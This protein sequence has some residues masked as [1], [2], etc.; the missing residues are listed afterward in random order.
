M[1]DAKMTIRL[2][3]SELEFAKC[4]AQQSGFSL[5]ALISRYLNRLQSSTEGEI[6]AE[7]KAITG[8]VPHEVDAR[9]EFHTHRM[10]KS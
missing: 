4:Y 1:N 2:P 10:R 7:I 5:T 8:I 3:T 9:K 6:P